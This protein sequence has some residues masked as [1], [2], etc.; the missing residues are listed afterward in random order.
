MSLLIRKTIRRLWNCGNVLANKLFKCEGSITDLVELHSVMVELQQCKGPNNEDFFNLLL[1]K[2]QPNVEAYNALLQTSQMS[3]IRFD[4]KLF[5]G[6]EAVLAAKVEK[7]EKEAKAIADFVAKAEE[8]RDLRNHQR[9]HGF[10]VSDLTMIPKDIN[11]SMLLFLTTDGPD[12]RKPSFIET[13]LGIE[14]ENKHRYRK[15]S[16]CIR[17]SVNTVDDF[18]KHFDHTVQNVFHC[19]IFTKCNNCT[20]LAACIHVIRPTPSQLLKKSIVCYVMR[21]VHSQFRSLLM[22]IYLRSLLKDDS[23]P[24]LARF[25]DAIENPDSLYRNE[26]VIS[27]RRYPNCLSSSEEIDHSQ[28]QAWVEFWTERKHSLIK[29]P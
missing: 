21:N 12:A 10:M 27:L 24:I 4:F 14:C 2:I 6:P 17:T 15:I 19:M 28:Y 1:K 22:V 26:L 13:C 29:S 8:E 25:L 3:Q 16:D 20:A 18:M 23:S 5:D 9:E 11:T 7:E